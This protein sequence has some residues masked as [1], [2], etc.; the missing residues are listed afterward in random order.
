MAS[1][2]VP[3]NPHPPPPPSPSHTTSP[4]KAGAK[5]KGQSQAE[6]VKTAPE[7][8][9][10]GSGAQDNENDALES[11]NTYIGSTCNVL[12]CALRLIY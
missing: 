7:G 2:S 3:V 5:K 12:V 8:G 1:V 11:F 10:E 9:E 4:G 6:P